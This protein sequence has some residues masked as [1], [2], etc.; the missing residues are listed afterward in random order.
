MAVTHRIYTYEDLATTP[1]DG[2]RYEIISGELIVS[3]APILDHQRVVNRLNVWLAT[4]VWERRL[5][6]VYTS[7]VDVRLSRHNSVQPDIV[8]ISRERLHIQRRQYIDG[9]PNLVIE[10][11]SDRTRGIDLVRK[12]A[13]YAMAGVA[14]YWIADLTNRTLL[15]LTLVEGDY[16]EVE[17]R[18]GVAR[19]LVV[20][21][22]EVAVEDVFASVTGE[23]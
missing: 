18:D 14:E 17:Q 6:E 8:F 9:A 22:F 23:G 5:G 10:V 3:P 2:N 4:F 11:L 12:R 15:V 7:P 16:V 21:G 19:S 20:P 1:D 13:L